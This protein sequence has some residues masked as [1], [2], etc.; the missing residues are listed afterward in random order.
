MHHI[1]RYIK[2]IYELS[3]VLL[4][5]DQTELNNDLYIIYPMVL[6]ET[7]KSI[8][9]FL[10]YWFFDSF[11][12]SFCTI[13]NIHLYWT[14]SFLCVNDIYV[15]SHT[16][17]LFNEYNNFWSTFNIRS[18]IYTH[19]K[20]AHNESLLLNDDKKK[21]LHKINLLWY[22][23]KTFVVHKYIN[24]YKIQNQLYSILFVWMGT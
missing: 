6:Y 8:T 24:I 19:K 20:C 11:F 17:I 22:F 7:T 16:I 14:I 1:N 2:R 10:C 15:R 3:R 4:E 13:L 9:F 12:S 23:T 21:W 5:N 18:G